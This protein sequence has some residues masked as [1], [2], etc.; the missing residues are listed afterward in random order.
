MPERISRIDMQQRQIDESVKRETEVLIDL[1]NKAEQTC[2][3]GCEWKELYYTTDRL[4]KELNEESV[5]V[6][7]RTRDSHWVMNM[8]KEMTAEIQMQH[9]LRLDKLDYLI[10]RIS[11]DVY[12]GAEPIRIKD[13]RRYSL[14]SK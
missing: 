4:M 7:I 8:F 9:Q 2:H 12:G 5:E 13:N 10:E 14:G 6:L 3:S 1:E 11:K